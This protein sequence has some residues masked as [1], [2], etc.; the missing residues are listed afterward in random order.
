MKLNDFVA[1]ALILIGL[2]SGAPSNS[3]SV[4]MLPG[5]KARN[6]DRKDDSNEIVVRKLSL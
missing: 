3:D 2:S 4:S 6:Q 5:S 1:F